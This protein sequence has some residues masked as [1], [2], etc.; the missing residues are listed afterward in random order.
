MLTKRILVMSFISLVL[1]SFSA[2]AQ[3]PAPIYTENYK[4]LIENDRVRVM[5]F[6]LKK[7]A[8]E[9]F[10]SHPA[11]VL[12]VLSPLK[13]RFT[14]PDGKMG[15][16]EAKAGD[17]LFNEPVTHASEN[18][19]DEDAHGILVELKTA[20]AGA[21]SAHIRFEDSFLTAVTFIRGVEGKE[22]ELK[23]E[24]LELTAPTRAEPGNIAYD[25]YQSPDKKN[26]FMRFEVW[27]SPQALE[28]HKAT[29]HLKASF[30]KRKQQGWMT[31]ITTWKRVRDE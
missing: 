9:C 8:K 26:E 20:P 4:V 1:L 14:F 30:E 7:G 5:H 24:L 27:R 10:H 6:Q 15:L 25:L 12:Y 23:R 31:E 22:E 17:V 21:A 11:H 16:R 19:G 29:P 28:E 2:Q 18:M 3:D 13:I